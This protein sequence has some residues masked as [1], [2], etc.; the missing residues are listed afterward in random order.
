M[1]KINSV[2]SLRAKRSNPAADLPISMR[3]LRRYA[4]RNDK[5]LPLYLVRRGLKEI[6]R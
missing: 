5:Q 4:S 1:P 2:A 3:L 6:S